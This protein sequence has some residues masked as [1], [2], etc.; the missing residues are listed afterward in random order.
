MDIK[1]NI[2]IV[3]VFIA[4]FFAL[5][6]FYYWWSAHFGSESTRLKRRIASIAS[7]DLDKGDYQG[8]LKNRYA[9]QADSY[10]QFLISLP[11]VNKLDELLMQ[12]GKLWTV[13]KLFRISGIAMLIA[14]I[15]GL[16]LNLNFN[17]ILL[18][19]FVAAFFPIFYL[20]RARGQR[21][22]KFEEQLPEAID[23]ICRSLKAGHAFTSAF[24]LVG[25]EMADPIAAEFR[26][27]MEENNLGMSIHDA[28]HNLAKRVPLTDLRFFVIAVLVQRETGGNLAE[29]LSNISTIIRDRFKLLRHIRVLTAEGRLSALVLAMM[30]F[31]MVSLLSALNPTYAPMMFGTPTGQHYLKVGLVM[32]L[33]GVIWMR[34]IVNIKM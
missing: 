31:I 4:A 5:E 19:T 30:P 16:I 27:A 17:L 11:L 8:I 15:L 25:Q 10:S 33:I 12:S 24:S 1:F 13:A 6:A 28:M 34:K 32:M 26:I 22:R 18:E 9:A 3:F 14:F 20:I 29:I 2:F 21:F 23:S 7:H